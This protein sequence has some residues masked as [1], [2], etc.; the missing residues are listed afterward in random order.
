[1]RVLEYIYRKLT[2]KEKVIWGHLIGFFLYYVIMVGIEGHMYKWRYTSAF[3]WWDVW[4]VGGGFGILRVLVLTYL[5]KTG[6]GRSRLRYF[7]QPS[8]MFK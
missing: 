3:I 2:Y 8:S 4:C 6:R 1:M 5:F 7:F